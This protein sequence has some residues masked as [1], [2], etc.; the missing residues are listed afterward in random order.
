M[1]L[2]A[3]SPGCLGI[4]AIPEYASLPEIPTNI[5]TILKPNTNQIF[6]AM[7]SCCAPSEVHKIRDGCFLYCE[8]PGSAGLSGQDAEELAGELSSCV[9][10]RSNV[11][12]ITNTHVAAASSGKLQPGLLAL[13]LL[14]SLLAS[15]L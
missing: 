12:G 11:T 5:T 1:S 14:A 7:K 9:Y 4:N 6:S 10:R 15:K 2:N 8:V 13:G 3:S